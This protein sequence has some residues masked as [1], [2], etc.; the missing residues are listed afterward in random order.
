MEDILIKRQWK[1]TGQPLR[2]AKNFQRQCFIGSKEEN[3][4][5]EDTDLFLHRTASF[6][7]S[8]WFHDIKRKKIKEKILDLGTYWGMHSPIIFYLAFWISLGGNDSFH[9]YTSLK[10]ISSDYLVS[11]SFA[12][13]EQ[14]PSWKSSY[15]HTARKLHKQMIVRSI[16][17]KIL[18]ENFRNM[19]NTLDTHI[20]YSW[21]MLIHIHLCYICEV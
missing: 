21:L 19:L 11:A 9:A 17:K 20:H 7:E 3:E 12:S 10:N 13:F 14:F 16:L 1:S 5:E 6:C 4:R 15:L 18:T 2:N 8:D